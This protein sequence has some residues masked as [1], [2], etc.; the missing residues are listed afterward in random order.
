MIVV[1]ITAFEG[2]NMKDEC[3]LC[4]P[5]APVSVPRM[6]DEEIKDGV[7]AAGA[8]VMKE[9]RSVADGLSVLTMLWSIRLWIWC[10]GL[11]SCSCM[12]SGVQ[13]VG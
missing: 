11:L 2:R 10:A 4:T 5:D 3:P 6:T 8:V 12:G 7:V 13:G 9:C 1:V